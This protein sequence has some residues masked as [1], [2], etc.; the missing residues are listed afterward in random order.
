VT[1]LTD[2]DAEFLTHESRDGR[3]FLPHVLSLAEA[4]GVMFECPA[5]GKHSVLTWF[6]GRGVPDTASPGP[7][8]WAPSG[9]GLSDL[10]LSPSVDLSTSA[11][12]CKWHGW[13]KNGDAA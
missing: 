8:R 11:S 10:T 3:E 1:K 12:P 9:T 7:G 13:V 5:C 6:K 2:L 4:Q